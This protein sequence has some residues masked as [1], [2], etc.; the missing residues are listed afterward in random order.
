[1]A[2]GRFYVPLLPLLVL[3]LPF[4]WFTRHDKITWLCIL[5]LFI[6]SLQVHTDRWRVGSSNGVDSIGWLDQ[7]SSQCTT[8]G[9]WIHKNTRADTVLATTAAGALSYY[10]KRQT[11]DLLGLT[12]TQIAQRPALGTRPG[13]QKSASFSYPL[14]RGANLLIYHPTMTINPPHPHPRL[15]DALARRGFQWYQLQVP[16][17]TPEWWGVWA[18]PQVFESYSESSQR[19]NNER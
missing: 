2:L 14:R 8:L 9:Q 16:D 4:D 6:I 13:H 11:I 5:L 12:D 7:F 3:C 17:L 1:M 19:D 10:S 18:L 15:K